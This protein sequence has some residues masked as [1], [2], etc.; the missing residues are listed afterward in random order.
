MKG[1]S[2]GL[3]TDSGSTSMEGQRSVAQ[4]PPLGR[5]PGKQQQSCLTLTLCMATSPTLILDPKPSQGDPVSAT[6]GEHSWAPLA[7]LWGDAQGRAESSSL[8]Q[9]EEGSRSGGDTIHQ[10]GP[11]EVMHMVGEAKSHRSRH[12]PAQKL[13]KE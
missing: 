8:W 9:A 12:P 6:A 4:T 2:H 13:R 7:P 1:S 10:L 5:S 3:G 11:N